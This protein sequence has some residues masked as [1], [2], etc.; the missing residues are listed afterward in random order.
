MRSWL[1]R[2]SSL[3]IL[4]LW[5]DTAA[6][7]RGRQGGCGSGLDH[8]E[9]AVQWLTQSPGARSPQLADGRVR[10]DA[11]ARPRRRPRLGRGRDERPS[12]ARPGCRSWWWCCITPRGSRGR[13]SVART[14]D[15]PCSVVEGH[16]D[17]QRRC[18][19][20]FV[21]GRIR[22][23]EA[24]VE[25]TT[26]SGR[27]SEREA[28]SIRELTRGRRRA[29]VPPERVRRTVA[30]SWVRHWHNSGSV[31][32]PSTGPGSRCAARPTTQQTPRVKPTTR[33]P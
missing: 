18:V 6:E 29:T 28:G 31:T 19:R 32:G 25:K 16:G 33:S 21:P 23:S 11:S 15:A 26:N 24:S 14:C 1:A 13:G 17:H 5:W 27:V 9:R 4:N 10:G 30:Q 12:P 20:A 7:G 3:F 22:K 8:G 2:P